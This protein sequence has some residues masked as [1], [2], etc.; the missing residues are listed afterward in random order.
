M[1][2]RSI[3]K[4]LTVVTKSMYEKTEIIVNVESGEVQTKMINIRV[5]KGVVCCL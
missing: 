2:N 4:H 3:P 1:D 5:E